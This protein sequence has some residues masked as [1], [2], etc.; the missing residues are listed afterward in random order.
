MS[1][2]RRY[3]V[4][5]DPYSSGAMLGSA[6]RDQGVLPIAV[7][8]SVVPPEV[9][10]Q[11]WMPSAY[12][13]VVVYDKSVPD[14]VE[15]LR[16]LD[17][18]CVIPGAESGVEL[19]DELASALTP[20]LANVPSL[21]SSRRHKMCMGE[22]V[23]AAGLPHIRQICTNN[24]ADVQDWIKR[25]GLSS[26]A[27]V[28]KPPKSAGTDGVIKVESSRDWLPS[29]RALLGQRNKLGGTNDEVL[30]QEFI[31]GDEYVVDTFSYH[32]IHTVTDICRYRKVVNAEHIA[33][34]DSLEFLPS[35]CTVHSELIDYTFGVLDAL[36]VRF[37]P[38][39]SEIMLTASGPRLIETGVRM[40]GGGHPEFCRLATGDSQLDRTVAFYIGNGPIRT[41]FT[42]TRKVMVIF[43][44]ARARGIV[45]NSEIFAAAS[46]L[47]SHYK[48]VIS[49]KNGDRV[50]KTSDLFT[51]LGFIVLAHERPNQVFADCRTVKDMENAL[52]ID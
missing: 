20:H 23:S 47:A 42:L 5:V 3:T 27:L 38:A 12:D 19:A 52:V 16:A 26:Q 31:T 30:V 24:V 34:Y 33:V 39:H 51:A 17:P 41:D 13:T 48:S 45:R 2:N 36:G 40:H 32:G 14:I 10:A 6:F 25:E 21:A 18:L 44:I 50:V 8:T 22:A 11:S 4:I 35:D 46:R 29:F 1:V 43:L 7:T 37:G 28:L 9:Y 15:R 49:V